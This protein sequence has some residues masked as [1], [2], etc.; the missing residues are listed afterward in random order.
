MQGG[1]RVPQFDQRR[2]MRGEP[3]AQEVLGSQVNSD[4]IANRSREFSAV[5]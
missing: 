4:H 2:G 1:E 5:A 3:G